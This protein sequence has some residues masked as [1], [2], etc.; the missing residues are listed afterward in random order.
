MRCVATDPR[1]VS[2]S[3]ISMTD[4]TQLSETSRPRGNSRSLR[5]HEPP[6][7]EKGERPLTRYRCYN[8]HNPRALSG[9]ETHPLL[10]RSLSP[11]CVTL[12]S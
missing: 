9:V 10:S 5:D 7:L 3:V 1:P 8:V 4:V 12:C 2:V 11:R 6:R